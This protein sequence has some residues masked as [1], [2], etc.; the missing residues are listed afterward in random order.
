M[1]L[2]RQ[3]IQQHENISDQQFDLVMHRAVHRRYKKGQFLVHES[4][5]S[6]KTHFVLKGAAIGYFLDK[7]GSEHVIQFALEG[8]WIS[9]IRSYISGE[10]AILSVKAIEEVEVLEFTAASMKELYKDVP[11][12]Q[13]YFLTITQKAFAAFQ[14]RVLFN[15]S[16]SAEERYLSFIA[17]YPHL[18]KRLSQKTIASYLGIS[19][20]F[21]SKIKK[22]RLL[23]GKT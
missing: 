1:E 6:P 19:P 9:D 16:F 22:G 5:I 17:T 3:S 4:S 7:K 8:W 18:E 15:L 21:Y 23:K 12:L 13:S 14:E 2:L 11:A 10:P 20:E